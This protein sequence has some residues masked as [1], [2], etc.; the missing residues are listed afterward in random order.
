MI[1]TPTIKVRDTGRVMV[2][3]CAK[4]V[5]TWRGNWRERMGEAEGEEVGRAKKRKG[6][7]KGVRME[8]RGCKGVLKRRGGRDGSK[9]QQGTEVSAR[10]PRKNERVEVSRQVPSLTLCLLPFQLVPEQQGLPV[11]SWGLDSRITPIALCP[12]NMEV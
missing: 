10:L 2:P 12:R 4:D 3:V 8:R 5:T 1:G 6:K 11:S 9:A 7:R